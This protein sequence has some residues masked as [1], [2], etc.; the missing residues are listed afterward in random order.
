MANLGVDTWT[1]ST[2]RKSRRIESKARSSR[3]HER[4]Y[5]QFIKIETKKTPIT[6]PC[7]SSLTRGFFDRPLDSKCFN[8]GTMDELFVRVGKRNKLIW[9]DNWSGDCTEY[10]F[11]F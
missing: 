1:T 5:L 10:F 4:S 6:T 7:S 2:R 8:I 9:N 11:S 3:S